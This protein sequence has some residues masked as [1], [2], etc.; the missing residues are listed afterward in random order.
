MEKKSLPK[1][2]K[3]HEGDLV[4]VP[5]TVYDYAEVTGSIDAS[6]ADTKAA[7]PKLTSVCGYINAVG[8]DTK[9]AFPKLTSVGGYIYAVGADT[10]AAFP[11][12]TSVGGYID[13]SG[14]DTTRCK[15]NDPDVV[16]RCRVALQAAFAS[17]GFSYADGILARVVS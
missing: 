14:A 10:K 6:G 1:V 16:E 17:Y 9:A 8:A 11:K 5:G 7:F 4:A 12:L 15:T 13:A 3:I 2:R